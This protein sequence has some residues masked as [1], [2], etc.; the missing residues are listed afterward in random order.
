MVLGIFIAVDWF[1]VLE[2]FLKME[3]LQLPRQIVWHVGLYG[4]PVGNR[5][6]RSDAMSVVYIIFTFYSCMLLF[7]IISF[8]PWLH[9]D[10]N[11]VFVYWMLMEMASYC[12][13]H[14]P[15][16]PPWWM[17]LLVLGRYV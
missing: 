16:G 9:T 3:E 13:K 1:I 4:G 2:F 8:V 6:K 5:C 10:A 17:I 11:E 12:W 7:H 14:C 15:N